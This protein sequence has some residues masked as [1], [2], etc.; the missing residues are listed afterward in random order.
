MNII[1]LS[2]D[3]VCLL[4]VVSYVASLTVIINKP[5]NCIG[6]LILLV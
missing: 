6:N 5:L 2:C 3:F 1:Y 4:V